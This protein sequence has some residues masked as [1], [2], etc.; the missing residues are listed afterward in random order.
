MKKT[1]KV[2][3]KQVREGGELEY[4]KKFILNG[5]VVTVAFDDFPNG[6]IA[7]GSDGEK[8]S[9]ADWANAVPFY[10]LRDLQNEYFRQSKRASDEY[11]EFRKTGLPYD[12]FT[13]FNIDYSFFESKIDVAI[14][15]EYEFNEKQAGFVH[16]RAYEDGHSSYG[17]VFD[18]CMKYAEMIK[19]FNKLS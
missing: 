11:S 15:H 18:Y 3:P 6:V 5:K 9:E 2:T 19:E 13:G 14:M 17:D 12:Q 16:G 1:S 7:F 8:I 4:G 10:T